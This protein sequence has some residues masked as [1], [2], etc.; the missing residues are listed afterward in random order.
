M[1]IIATAAVGNSH[2]SWM[3]L[4]GNCLG[5]QAISTS[6]LEWPGFK[7]SLGVEVMNEN[8]GIQAFISGVNISEERR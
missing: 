3:K 8:E 6:Q 4:A 5:T 1:L 7:Y 2:I